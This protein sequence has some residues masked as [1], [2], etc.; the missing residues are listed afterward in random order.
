MSS[1]CEDKAL[2]KENAELRERYNVLSAEKMKADGT[3]TQKEGDIARR[4]SEIDSLKERLG[5]AKQR[6]EELRGEIAIARAE[7]AKMNTENT[8]IIVRLKAAEAKLG[9]IEAT[10][11][12]RKTMQKGQL[13]GAVAYFFNSNYGY[14]PDVGAEICIVPLGEVNKLMKLS[15]FDKFMR[16]STVVSQYKEMESMFPG[17]ERKLAPYKKEMADFGV[18][19]MTE[20]ES[21]SRTF[22]QGMIQ[23]EGSTSAIKLSADGS[24]AFSRALVPGKYLVVIRSKNR[25][26]ANI[27][28]IAGSLYTTQI[29]V[30]SDDQVNV[31][32]KF[33]VW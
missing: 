18:N 5:E 33:E 10:E 19:S 7:S 28:E 27:V 13:S 24:G 31:G 25:K 14:K 30:K 12:Q 17:Q 20:W 2:L 32:A 6:V 1:G 21:W 22:F 16:L 23:V 11:L 15:D 29:D 3:L 8:E 9:Q 26:K 4:D